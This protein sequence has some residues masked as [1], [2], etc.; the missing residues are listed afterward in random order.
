MKDV[1]DI[2][3]NKT[4]IKHLAPSLIRGVTTKNGVPIVCPVHCHDRKTGRI[5]SRTTSGQDGSYILFGLNISENYI[6]ATDPDCE[7]N[8]AAQDNVK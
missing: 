8:L 4:A 5:L 7:F 2:N 6:I 1:F 3:L